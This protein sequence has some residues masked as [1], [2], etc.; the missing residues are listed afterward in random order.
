MVG[1]SADC[2]GGRTLKRNI[3]LERLVVLLH[4]PSF[5]IDCSYLVRVAL[6]IGAYQI[7]GNTAA[8]FVCEVCEVC[9]DL[10][11]QQHRK[12][13]PFKVDLT[14]LTHLQWHTVHAHIPTPL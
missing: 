12:L 14:Y 10:L 6:N 11:A 2:V 7:L 8:I 5:L 4:V 3:V 9:E 13:Y 1:L